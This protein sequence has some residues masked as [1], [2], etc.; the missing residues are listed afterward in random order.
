VGGDTVGFIHARSDTELFECTFDI[1]PIIE[2]HGF[3]W[4]TFKVESV[5]VKVVSG[6][7]LQA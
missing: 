2:R 4:N 6:E 5:P 7:F 3:V 1:G